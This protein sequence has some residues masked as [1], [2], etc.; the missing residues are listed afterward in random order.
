M[1]PIFK[2]SAETQAI[3]EYLASL[4]IG[5]ETSFAAASKATGIRIT[6]TTPAYQSAK[7]TAERDHNVVIES[8][9]GFGFVRVNAEGMVE[10]ASKFFR[11]VR[12]GSRREAHVQEI[13]IM[14]NLPRE[15]MLTATEQ[16][17]R[18][19]ILESTALNHRKAVSNKRTVDAP[20][21]AEDTFRR[22]YRKA[23]G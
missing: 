23:A 13:A 19:R 6:S 4:P 7:R 14:S 21:L 3:V 5:Q 11:K 8:I 16:L 20:E 18:L 10:R 2:Q 12:R 1:R 22:A 17:S 9:R 15:A